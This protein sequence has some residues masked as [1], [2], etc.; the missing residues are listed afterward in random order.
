MPGKN[1]D[2]NRKGVR[3]A[4]EKRIETKITGITAFSFKETF[5]KTSYAPSKI[6]EINARNN[7]LKN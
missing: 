7:H 4:Q 1:S 3:T 6:A 5:L 2:I